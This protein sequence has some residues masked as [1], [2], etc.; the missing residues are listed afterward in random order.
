MSSGQAEWNSCP[1]L[2]RVSQLVYSGFDEV[3]PL[4]ALSSVSKGGLDWSSPQIGK[5]GLRRSAVR[6]L[7]PEGTQFE[8]KAS[9][10]EWFT[11]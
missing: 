3:Y 1:S 10:Q 8:V 4:W 7:W 2:S 6:S 11:L 9:R 5:V